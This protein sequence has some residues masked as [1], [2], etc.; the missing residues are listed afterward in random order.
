MKKK[1]ACINAESMF[2][3]YTST[4]TYFLILNNHISQAQKPRAL[5]NIWIWLNEKNVMS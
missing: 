4:Y 1:K 5:Q 2:I 3:S